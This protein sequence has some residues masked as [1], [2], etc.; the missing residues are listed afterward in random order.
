MKNFVLAAVTAATLALTAGA[1]TAQERA[2]NEVGV[3]AGSL[4]DD[5][6]FG[7]RV[8]LYDFDLPY[9]LQ[10]EGTYD[11]TVRQDVV[12]LNLVGKTALTERVNG[13]VLAGVGYDWNDR[14]G[15]RGVWTYGAG[16]TYALTPSTELDLR[17]RT[18]N[19]FRDSSDDTAVTLGVNYAF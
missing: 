14:Q 9:G 7:A 18:F 13:Y 15:D 17:V 8:G 10:L 4:A 2:I 11:G 19:S 3:V 5:T 16:L 1:A 12:G 6:A